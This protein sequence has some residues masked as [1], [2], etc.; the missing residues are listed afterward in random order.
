MRSLRRFGSVMALVVVL[1]G[2]IPNAHAVA[3]QLPPVI[4]PPVTGMC[5]TPYGAIMCM[6]T[7]AGISEWIP[8]GV[9]SGGMTIVGFGPYAEDGSWC[10]TDTEHIFAEGSTSCNPAIA[11]E[12]PGG[13]IDDVGDEFTPGDPEDFDPTGFYTWEPVGEPCH[14][15]ICV[16]SAV[17]RQIDR[18]VEWYVEV[19]GSAGNA[20]E[21]GDIQH[22][23]SPSGAAITNSFDTPCYFAAPVRLFAAWPNSGG[24]GYLTGATNAGGNCGFPTSDS[25]WFTHLTGDGISLVE[26]EVY[27][28]DPGTCHRV[29]VDDGVTGHIGIFEM[30][31]SGTI[32]DSQFI[33]VERQGVFEG[34]Y[35]M[36]TACRAEDGTITIRESSGVEDFVIGAAA[37][38]LPNGGCLPGE[39]PVSS[40]VELCDSNSEVCLPV[41]DWTMPGVAEEHFDCIYAM[42]GP[43]PCPMW[44]EYWDGSTWETCVP[45]TAGPCTDW[46][47]NTARDVV[48]RCGWGGDYFSASQCEILKDWYNHDD[49]ETEADV[50]IVNPNEPSPETESPLPDPENPSAPQ[51]GVI[52]GPGTAPSAR[53]SE[54][55]L[56]RIIF[57]WS[58]GSAPG[59]QNACWPT[60]WG[61][62]NPLQWIMRPIMCALTFLFVPTETVQMRLEEF[63]TEATTTTKLGLLTDSADLL[64][65][66]P[67]P[68]VGGACGWGIASTDIGV[69]TI[70][71]TQLILCPSEY[72]LS[73]TASTARSW[74]FGVV[75]V[76]VLGMVY[77]WIGL[78]RSDELSVDSDNV[79]GNL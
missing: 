65:G 11:V 50:P 53:P 22:G 16:V 42:S 26:H 20:C 29:M 27:G 4:A 2:A 25:R 28:G 13:T 66:I 36:T 70:P 61:L 77:R 23:L 67:T 10:M 56:S 3:F 8:A 5:S 59:M 41:A 51:P 43:N 21:G 39:I 15:G 74:G 30:N 12:T 72:G 48:F 38:T 76:W 62:L 75:G 55:W 63:W 54:G 64:T 14:E 57:E 73:G 18:S 33:V 17:S 37:G 58:T 52:T 35:E 69:M 44:L 32:T 34:T 40:Q 60:G 49:P 6:V 19:D 46:W 68:S 7:G 9:P 79:T 71:E 78:G 31:G 1:I 45:A 47:E 24:L